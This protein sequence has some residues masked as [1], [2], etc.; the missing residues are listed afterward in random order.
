MIYLLYFGIIILLIGIL[1]R[2]FAFFL[3]NKIE[4]NSI[5]LSTAFQSEYVPIIYHWKGWNLWFGA[6]FPDEEFSP[7]QKNLTTYFNQQPITFSVEQ[8][9]KGQLIELKNDERIKNKYGTI[10]WKIKV[11]TRK[12]SNGTTVRLYEQF[13]SSSSL[14]NIL[15][16]YQFKKQWKEQH[17]ERI[18]KLKELL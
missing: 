6:E 18:T 5:F 17:N 3:S 9:L 7:D 11:E 14:Q 10:S 8:F 13:I 16:H 15:L 12:E 1:V 2:V 4:M